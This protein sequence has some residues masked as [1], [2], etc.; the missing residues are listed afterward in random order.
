MGNLIPKDLLEQIP[1]LYETEEISN[2]ICQLKLFSPDS[3]W[4][5]Y[6]IEISIDKDICYGY[7]KG[8]E[9]ELGYFS[10]GELESINDSFGLGVELDSSFK[11]TE[12]SKIK[13]ELKNSK[14][15]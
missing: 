2:P 14:G 1:K 12:L 3:I 10:L 15:F 13:Q 8:F 7:I 4:E 9:S 5:W 6:I 11:S